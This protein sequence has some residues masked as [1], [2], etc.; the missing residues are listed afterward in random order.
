MISIFKYELITENIPDW[1]IS[2]QQLQDLLGEHLKGKNINLIFSTLS[3]I[4]KINLDFRNISSPTDVL[5]FNV[6]DNEIDGEVYVCPEYIKQ[7]YEGNKGVEEVL[8]VC[9]HGILHILGYNHVG[10]FD[11]KS[12]ELEEMFVEQERIVSEIKVKLKI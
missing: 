11:E 12:E 6:E 4:Q 10:I 8:R 9:V 3:E 2:S 7:S 5:S 1:N